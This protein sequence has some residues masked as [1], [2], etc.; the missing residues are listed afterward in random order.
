MAVSNHFVYDRAPR[1]TGESTT[2]LTVTP[3]DALGWPGDLPQYI[4]K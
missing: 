2:E 4:W 3:M 1:W